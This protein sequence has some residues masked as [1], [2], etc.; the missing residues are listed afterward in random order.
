MQ[1]RVDTSGRGRRYFKEVRFRQIRALVETAH[2]GSF[3]AAARRLAVSTPSV[4]RQVRALEDEYGVPLVT[5]HG[6]DVRLTAE[7]TLLLEI[8]APLVEGFDSLRQLFADRSRDAVRELRIALPGTI[9]SGI[10]HDPVADYC[11]SH[12]AVKL[13]LTDAPSQTAWEMLDRGEADLAITGNPAGRR[14]PTRLSVTPLGSYA[15]H[16][17]CPRSHPLATV[18]RL[19]LR[20]VV[21]YPLIDAGMKSSSRIQFDH[22]VSRAGLADRVNVAMSARHDGVIRSYVAMGI[23]IALT[24]IPVFNATAAPTRGAPLVVRDASHIFGDERIVLLQRKARHEPAH[25]REFREAVV[26]ACRSDRGPAS[27]PLP[28]PEGSP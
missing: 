10:L 19:T 21:K 7:G 4:W 16:I 27:P 3:A 2:T 8:A 28:V 17:L 5:V 6:R 25:I 13:Q 15:F 24:T 9:V 12:P 14:L 1:D 23:G 11:R 26:A 18:P 22:A 20:E